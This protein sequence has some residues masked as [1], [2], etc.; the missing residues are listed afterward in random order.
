[1][2]LR[3]SPVA[4]SGLLALAIGCGGAATPP[5]EPSPAAPASPASEP[6]PSND[7]DADLSPEDRAMMEDRRAN[8]IAVCNGNGNN[9]DYCACTWDQLREVVSREELLADRATPEQVRE[10]QRRALLYC[11]DELSE[12]TVQKAFREGCMT[13]ANQAFCDCSY[14]ELRQRVSVRDIATRGGEDR[15]GFVKKRTEAVQACASDVDEATVKSNFVRGC[16]DSGGDEAR[17]LC[18]WDVAKKEVTLVDIA[19]DRID[20]EKLRPMVREQCRQPAPP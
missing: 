14:R 18:A 5:P 15:E 2:R 12:E 16:M 4:G 6:T 1:M 3:I 7:P 9:A 11:V 13:K 17:C 10:L 8:F 20:L 19:L